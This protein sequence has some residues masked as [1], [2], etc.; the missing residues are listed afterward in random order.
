MSS[1]EK[2][3]GEIVKVKSLE[4]GVIDNYWLLGCEALYSG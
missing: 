1:K 3:E 2:G 4:R